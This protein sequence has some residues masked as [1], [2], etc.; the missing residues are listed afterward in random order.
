MADANALYFDAAIRHQIGVRRF[1]SHEVNEILVLLE[2]ADRDL[3]RR[4]R[5][6]LAKEQAAGLTFVERRFITKRISSMLA[7]LEAIRLADLRNVQAKLRGDLADL[8]TLEAGFEGRMLTSAVGFDLSLGL[9]A[10]EQLRAIVTSHPFKGKLLREWM[11]GIQA[12]DRARIREA[13][14]IGM[15]E[16]EG[17]DGIV[18]RVVGSRSA[19]YADGTVAVTRRQ[20]EAIV[21]TAVNHVSNAAREAVWNAN[22]DVIAGMRWTSTLDGNTTMICKARD[23]AMGPIPGKPLPPGVRRLRPLFA[24]PPAHISCRSIMVAVIDGVGA[25]GSRPFVTHKGK[26]VD[27]RKLAR[28][29][30]QTITEARRRWADENIGR[31]PAK[32]TYNEWLKTQSKAFQIDTLGVTR[33]KLFRDGGLSLDKFVDRSGKTLT[34]KQLARTQPEAFEAAGL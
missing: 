19:R 3:V 21:R 34:L 20:T 12:A 7:E 16:G 15:V 27:F 24:R 18:R 11:A 2:K 14:R 17:I 1:A 13:V 25:L 30:G 33:A 28:E 5:A 4:L 6:A 23:G 9:P 31:V 10:P 8:S 26:P 22:T 29:N 32:T